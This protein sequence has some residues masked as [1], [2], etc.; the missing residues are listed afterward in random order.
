MYDQTFAP[1]EPLV[2]AYREHF[3]LAANLATCEPLA[4][5]SATP[6]VDSIRAADLVDRLGVSRSYAFELTKRLRTP[7]LALAVQIENAFGIPA[8][9]W[10]A[11]QPRP[12][13]P[14]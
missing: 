1:P 11:D 2:N 12:Q 4:M 14:D 3:S 7:S 13:A 8:A 5:K 10:L 6:T 9:A